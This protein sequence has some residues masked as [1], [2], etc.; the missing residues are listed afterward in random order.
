MLFLY[1]SSHLHLTIQWRRTETKL[2]SYLIPIWTSL[3][4]INSNW[5]INSHTTSGWEQHFPA[6]SSK[7]FCSVKS[8]CSRGESTLNDY[9]F[10]GKF[11]F[12][13]LHLQT[14]LLLLFLLQLWKTKNE[15]FSQWMISSRL[16][17]WFL[18]RKDLA[19]QFN[20]LERNLMCAVH[21]EMNKMK[22]S[23]GFFLLLL[24]LSST[25]LYLISRLL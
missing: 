8:T 22:N 12:H 21:E 10:I 19:Q 2:E 23:I 6:Y 15:T 7:A 3:Q 18:F 1:F 4:H 25:V 5:A 11:I 20:V 16:I 9:S 13:A 17:T 24:M 14:D